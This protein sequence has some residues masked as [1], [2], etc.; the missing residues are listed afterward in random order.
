[1]HQGGRNAHKLAIL[2]GGGKFKEIGFK[3]TDMDF[4][5]LRKYSR[6]EIFAIFGIPKGVISAS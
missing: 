6:D 4:V 1:M 3:Q 2:E 5:A